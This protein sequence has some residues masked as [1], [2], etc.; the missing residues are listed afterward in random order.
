MGRKSLL[1]REPFRRRFGLGIGRLRALAGFLQI[2]FAEAIEVSQPILSRIERGVYL[3]HVL[4][5]KR[6]ATAL[7]LTV[8]GLYDRINEVT[9]TLLCA[10]I[11][12]DDG[13]VHVSQPVETGLVFSGHR[14]HNII[15]QL[16]AV[17]GKG[18]PWRK[19]PY[20]Q[21]FLT[22]DGRFV[23]RVEG[24]AIARVA[25]QTTSSKPQLYSEDLY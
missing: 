11:W 9:E 18:A 16:A 6:M 23:D 25:G 2:D 15:G 17:Y 12:I 24:L 13:V 19:G 21:G 1:E 10:A 14:H 8:Q 20:T 22:V 4:L 7:E 3:P 5:V